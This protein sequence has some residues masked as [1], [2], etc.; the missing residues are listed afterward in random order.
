MCEYSDRIESMWVANSQQRRGSDCKSSRA[1]K[2]IR[3]I[4]KLVVME[5]DLLRMNELLW[6]V[7]PQQRGLHYWAQRAVRSPIY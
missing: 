7:N 5:I 1:T 6:V 4:N 2:I 3:K